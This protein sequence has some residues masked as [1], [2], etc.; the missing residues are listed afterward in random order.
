MFLLGGGSLSVLTTVQADDILW[1]LNVPNGNW[2]DSFNWFN[3]SG[4]ANRVPTGDDHV[5]LYTDNRNTNVTYDSN[6]PSINLLNLGAQS[7]IPNNPYSGTMTLNLTGGTLS[8]IGN[9]LE[10]G[11]NQPTI[12]GTG[13]G[14][15]DQ[16]GGTFLISGLDGSNPPQLTGSLVLGSETTGIGTYN[17]SGT[18][19]LSVALFEM[20]GANGTGT[21]NQSAGSH[22]VGTNLYLGYNSGSNGTYSLNGTGSLGVIGSEAV[23]YNGT[24]IFSQSGGTN[25]VERNL[26]IS[27]Y[28]LTG[29]SGT[30]NLSGGTLNVNGEIVNNGTFNQTN[31]GSSVKG[32]FATTGIYNL[33][34]GTLNASG[35]ISNTGTL[36]QTGG[37]NTSASGAAA[38]I[39]SGGTYNLGGGTFNTNG[40]FTNNGNVNMT[41]GNTTGQLVLGNGTNM[42]NNNTFNIIGQGNS[43]GV[44]SNGGWSLLSNNIQ[45]T[46]IIVQPVSYLA[47]ANPID[48]C[49][50]KH[51]QQSH[52][53]LDC[54]TDIC[55]LWCC[56]HQYYPHHHSTS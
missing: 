28:P 14:V 26:L 46:S 55:N 21:F 43:G 40:G 30:Y 10:V 25:N 13:R 50:R 18:G 52:R 56:C 8:A 6:N 37:N 39:G 44:I 22:I 3:G 45:N 41:I 16:T 23:G 15:L 53:H 19:S 42:T 9:P 33:S 1:N 29:S 51:Y 54:V 17:L 36:N 2:N 20:V 24:G 7:G 38:T 47:P 31:G 11:G 12:G 34:N 5:L 35:G 27:R 32:T 48:S 49:F 4:G